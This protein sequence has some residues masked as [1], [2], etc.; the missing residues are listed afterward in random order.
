[1]H[2]YKLKRK[3]K[4]CLH[5]FI[6]KIIKHKNFLSQTKKD[7]KNRKVNIITQHYCYWY[8]PRKQCQCHFQFTAFTKDLPKGNMCELHARTHISTVPNSVQFS[9]DRERETKKQREREKRFLSLSLSLKFLT[10]LFTSPFLPSL[11]SSFSSSFHRLGPYNFILH[12][13][14]TQYLLTQPTWFYYVH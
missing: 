6:P 9:R 4:F 11:F 8:A 12:I 13:I 10:V 3:N 1:M 14:K 7:T 5:I 2:S